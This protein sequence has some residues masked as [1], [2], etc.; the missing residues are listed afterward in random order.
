MDFDL[1]TGN[2]LIRQTSWEAIRRAL[3][4]DS[5]VEV[6]AFLDRHQLMPSGSK[7]SYGYE[8]V[9]RAIALEGGSR[10]PRFRYVAVSS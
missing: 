3:G 1:R 8:Q 2:V 6:Q 7:V 10:L 4:V 5:D 9:A